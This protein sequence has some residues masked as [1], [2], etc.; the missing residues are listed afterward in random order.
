MQSFFT[1]TSVSKFIKYLLMTTPLPTCS[2]LN[3]CDIMVEGN[4]YIYRG[5]VYKCTRTGIFKGSHKYT[6]GHLC[7]AETVY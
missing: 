5:N 1:T 3:D 7:C 6:E 4:F 2:F